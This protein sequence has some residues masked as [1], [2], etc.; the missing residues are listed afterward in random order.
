M[1]SRNCPECNKVLNYKNKRKYENANKVQSLCSSCAKKGDRNPCYGIK[2]ESHPRF[3]KVGL[4]G[5]LNP[6]KR[7]EVREK[8]SK[9]KKGMSN[10]REGYEMPD[11]TKIKIKNSNT[12]KKHN[13]SDEGLI[14][15]KEAR[16]KQIGEKCPGWKNGK[17]NK[18]RRLRNSD[19]YQEWRN[20]VF[21]RDNYICKHCLNEH[22]F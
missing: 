14:R 12:G 20:K 22:F 11:E 16:Q 7:I 19:K 6:S 8:I 1:Y 18:V 9:S 10:G 21:E 5:D 4:P 2:G 3:G 15:M 13:I 17:T